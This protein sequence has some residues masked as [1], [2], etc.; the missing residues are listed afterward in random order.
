LLDYGA[1][2]RGITADTCIEELMG[3]VPAP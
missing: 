3:K 2:A 1:Q